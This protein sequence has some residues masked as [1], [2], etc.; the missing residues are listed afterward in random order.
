MAYYK[1][2]LECGSYGD[3]AKMESKLSKVDGIKELK[4]SGRVGPIL[5]GRVLDDANVLLK[6]QN[7]RRKFAGTEM[8]VS[9]RSSQRLKAQLRQ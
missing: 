8:I 2:S 9:A 4:R 1:F 6:I 7:I 5:E 3:L